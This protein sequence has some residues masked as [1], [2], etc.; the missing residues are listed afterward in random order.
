MFRNLVPDFW[1][2]LQLVG[3]WVRNIFRNLVPDFWRVM[4]QM[5]RVMA[6]QYPACPVLCRVIVLRVSASMPCRGHPL[7]GLYGLI[8]EPDEAICIKIISKPL[9][10]PKSNRWPTIHKIIPSWA[11]P[12]RRRN[13]TFVKH[14]AMYGHVERGFQ[15]RVFTAPAWSGG[16]ELLRGEPQFQCAVAQPHPRLSCRK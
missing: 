16:E 8:F 14:I 7:V 4:F 9:L 2:C 13:A 11:G 12:V 10:T 6:C 15:D 5:L 3:T 1:T